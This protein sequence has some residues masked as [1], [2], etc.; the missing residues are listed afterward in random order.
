[1]LLAIDPTEKERPGVQ[2]LG[3]RCVKES[4]TAMLEVLPCYKICDPP[5]TVRWYDLKDNDTA[6]WPFFGRF[7]FF[8]IKVHF[9]TSVMRSLRKSHNSDYDAYVYAN[10]DCLRETVEPFLYNAGVDIVLHG[11]LF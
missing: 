10:A 11:A 4:W 8:G 6:A 1:M 2:C 9:C 5:D 3:L 7:V